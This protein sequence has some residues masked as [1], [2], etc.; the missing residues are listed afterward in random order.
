MKALPIEN[1]FEQLSES[2]STTEIITARILT[3]ISSVIRETRIK[4]N[5]N[6]KEFAKFMGVSQSMIS[7]WEG[8][9]YNFTVESLANIS[10]KLDLSLEVKFVDHNEKYNMNTSSKWEVRPGTGW[11]EKLSAAS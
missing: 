7:K 10:D 9:Y 6:Q 8:S 11:N 3:E 4:L 2:L 5:M 1:L